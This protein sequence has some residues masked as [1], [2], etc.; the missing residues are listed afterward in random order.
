MASLTV[1]AARMIPVASRAETG[2]E[3]V[4][5]SVRDASL[6]WFSDAARPIHARLP[7][8]Q[9]AFWLPQ[10]ERILRDSPPSASLAMGAAWVLDSPSLT[11]MQDHMQDHTHSE[12]LKLAGVP[13]IDLDWEKIDELC[14]EF[15]AA[16]AAPCVELAELATR[17]E[18]DEARW[19]QMRAQLLFSAPIF[20]GRMVQ[21]SSESMRVLSAAAAHDPENA[22]YDYLIALACW[23]EAATLTFV[24]D[25]D[26]LE[27]L[28]VARFEQGLE[29]FRRAQQLPQ[30]CFGEGGL[31]AAAQFVDR[32]G[33]SRTERADVAV[34]RRTEDRRAK[35][36]MAFRNW[37]RGRAE[38]AHQRGD[39][40]GAI[41]I[42]RQVLRVADQELACS[43]G[44]RT[45]ILPHSFRIVAVARIRE[46]AAEEPGLVSRAELAALEAIDHS[47]RVTLEVYRRADDRLEGQQASASA[48]TGTYLLGWGVEGLALAVPLAVVALAGLLAGRLLGTHT[49]VRASFGVLRHIACWMLAVAISFAVFGLGP[50]EV[51]PREWQ[52][53]IFCAVVWMLFAAMVVWFSV[54]HSGLRKLLP[55]E[56]TPERTALVHVI[57]LWIAAL[58]VLWATSRDDFAW[59]IKG[60]RQLSVGAVLSAAAGLSLFFWLF[61]I[62]WTRSLRRKHRA[63]HDVRLTATTV[64]GLLLLATAALAP[65]VVAGLAHL[66]AAA[67]RTLPEA[68][69][70]GRITAE[71]LRSAIQLEE[72]SWLWAVLQWFAHRGE[73]VA[74][75]LALATVA[76][77]A[78]RREAR[79]DGRSLWQLLRNG[80]RSRWAHVARRTGLS[81]AAVAI[82]CL[83]A[84]LALMPAVIRA[85]ESDY[86]DKMSYVRDPA[87][88]QQPF[89]NIVAEIEADKAA[90]E[91]ARAVVR[92][93]QAA[94]T[95]ASQP[96]PASQNN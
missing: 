73:L 1:L 11:F 80:P 70:A 48:G 45:N 69:G 32:V 28:D 54:K 93:R 44:E 72:G 5:A 38:D 24:E 88:Y 22:L 95:K 46:L 67:D 10:T 86:D 61:L 49:S 55:P 14:A 4:R 84:W 66:P 59:F 43:G 77:W 15:E 41:E 13:G 26:R 37:L 85:V 56:R 75:G 42:W 7:R 63:D 83:A 36:H 29:H 40:R 2:W 6:G 79:A 60:L 89:W 91:E 23:N 78:A 20:G 16:C 58:V 76:C 30:L 33:I 12:A 53:T 65:I 71:T 81:A 34:G 68:I 3:T 31:A 35:V 94:S 21:R 50:A 92:E 17:L 96:L 62:L 74:A 8:D 57:V 52:V 25:A 47:S 51:I 90:M 27:V 87:G 64:I 82:C 18:P 19:W 39:V 9:A